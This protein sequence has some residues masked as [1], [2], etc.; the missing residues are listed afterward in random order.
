MAQV[1]GCV[2]NLADSCNHFIM[3]RFW[4]SGFQKRH[5]KN[6]LCLHLIFEV[7]NS[8]ILLGGKK[9]P[10]IGETPILALD[11][12]YDFSGSEAIRERWHSDSNWEGWRLLSQTSWALQYP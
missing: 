4:E 3:Q 12:C 5:S 2:K 1:Y 8:L 9:H 6:Y 11:M 10:S 7:S